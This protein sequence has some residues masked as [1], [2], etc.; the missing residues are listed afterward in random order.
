MKDLKD[1]L[2]SA[3][4]VT[5]ADAHKEQRNQGY[6]FIE[7]LIEL[8]FCSFVSWVTA[9][10]L[11]LTDLSSLLFILCDNVLTYFCGNLSWY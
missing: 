11:S 3:G 6:V 9:I 5:Y 10:L 4:E 7:L 2:R 1:Y 8:S